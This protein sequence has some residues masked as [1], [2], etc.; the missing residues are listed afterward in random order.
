MALLAG[1]GY[2]TCVTGWNGLH[3]VALLVEMGYITCVTGWNGLHNVALLAG[4]GYITK[5]ALLVVMGYMRY[6]LEWAT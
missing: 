1:M 3:N 4:M 2:I 5:N 6:R